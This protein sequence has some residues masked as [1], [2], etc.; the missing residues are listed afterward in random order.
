MAT[1]A[2]DHEGEDTMHDKSTRLTMLSGC[3]ILVIFGFGCDRREHGTTPM[4]ATAAVIDSTSLAHASSAVH[5]PAHPPI[6]CPLHKQGVNPAHLKPFEDVEKYIAFL[7]RPDRAVWQKPDAV[8]SALGLKGTETVVDLGA[9]SGYFAFRIAKA[10]PN[11][12]V[13]AADTEAEMVRHVHHKVMTEGVRNL[14]AR[15]ISQADP[16]V[17]EQ[18]DLVF[19]C[20]VLHHVSDRR[21]WLTKLAQPLKT[22]SRL[23]L[24]E[25]REG[26]LPEGPPESM[27][28]P[29]AELVSLATQ[30]GFTLERE[31]ANVLPYQVFLV[32]TRI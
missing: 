13:I 15:L 19:V 8:V 32:F 31:V 21:E 26:K 6:D 20:D 17:S 4:K 14:E 24:I 12:K 30:S 28:I 7:E 9:G 3:I 11:G 22:G 23:V 10:L 5:D 25:F 1:S 27:K 16:A 29:R 2:T 18:T